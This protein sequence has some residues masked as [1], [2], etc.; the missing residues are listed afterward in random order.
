MWFFCPILSAAIWGVFCIHNSIFPL[1]PQTI[2]IHRS[3]E[4]ISEYSLGFQVHDKQIR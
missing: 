1:F 4:E 3:K 2:S